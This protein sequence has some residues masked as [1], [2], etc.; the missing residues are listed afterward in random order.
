M[1][2][3]LGIVICG[4]CGLI[5]GK[6]LTYLFGVMTRGGWKV[7]V[8]QI[9][10]VDIRS[11]VNAGLLETFVKKGIIYIRDSQTGETVKIGEVKEN[12]GD[13]RKVY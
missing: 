11:A 7:K 9:D 1:S 5:F 4:I 8:K 2:E 10:I 3:L 12:N 13:L 6:S